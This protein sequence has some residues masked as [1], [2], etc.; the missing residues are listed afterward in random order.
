MTIQEKW[1]VE[2]G[3]LSRRTLLRG[4]TLS[5]AAIALL[6]GAPTLLA[7]RRA[8]LGFPRARGSGRVH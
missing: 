2:A 6:A 8:E 1:I 5:A 4:G 7:F 3:A